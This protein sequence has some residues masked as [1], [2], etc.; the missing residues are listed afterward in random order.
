MKFKQEIICIKQATLLSLQDKFEF[1]SCHVQSSLNYDS[2]I[3]C[4]AT[5]SKLAFIIFT[6][7]LF[8]QVLCYL[9]PCPSI[10]S[11]RT[12]NIMFQ[13]FWNVSYVLWNSRLIAAPTSKYIC[14]VACCM[15][16]AIDVHGD[17]NF[18]ESSEWVLPAVKFHLRPSGNRPRDSFPFV[19][20][21]LTQW[22][23]ESPRIM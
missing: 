8:F 4:E 6:I 17:Y 20:T 10:R 11:R 5:E 22:L 3:V 1:Y 16:Q 23:V 18:L 2:I 19:I 9:M 13:Y 14:S 15:F 12:K 7:L 21:L